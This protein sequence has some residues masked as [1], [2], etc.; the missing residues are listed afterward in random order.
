MGDN[1][2][3]CN[4]C[5]PDEKFDRYSMEDRKSVVTRMGKDTQEIFDTLKA[6]SDSFPEDEQVEQLFNAI[7]AGQEA[8][9]SLKLYF[10]GWSAKLLDEN[11]GHKTGMWLRLFGVAQNLMS[12][13]KDEVVRYAQY[14]VTGLTDRELDRFSSLLGNLV[15]QIDDAELL[16]LRC[17]VF[18]MMGDKQNEIEARRK[19][20]DFAEQNKTPREGKRFIFLQPVLLQSFPK[21]MG[22]SI[23]RKGALT[24]V[25][26]S[27]CTNI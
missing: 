21:A 6:Q 22:N 4:R 2:F 13:Q 20:L 9:R 7:K 3:G 11:P 5:V 24:S 17:R 14:I 18:E 15:Q 19:Y 26:W 27:V 16:F 12:V 1:C 10:V 8:G 23:K 25:C